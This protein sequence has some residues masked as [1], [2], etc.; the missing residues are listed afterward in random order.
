MESQGGGEVV[1]DRDALRISAQKRDDVG[2]NFLSLLHFI[3]CFPDML[4]ID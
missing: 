2:K 3:S 4:H 1:E